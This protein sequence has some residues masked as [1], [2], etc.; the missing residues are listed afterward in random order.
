MPLY[1]KI[2]C[3]LRS[4][5]ETRKVKVGD[6]L[7]AEPELQRI[8]GTSRAP[9]RQAMSLLENER[10]VI[11][12]PGKGTFVS[13]ANIPTSWWLNFSPFRQHFE[14]E[15]HDTQTRVL[16]LEERVP[17]GFVNDFFVLGT[18]CSVTY[19]ERIRSVRHQPVIMNR[20]YVHP[21]Y[22]FSGFLEVEKHFSLRI[23]LMEK[24]SVEITRVDDVLTSILAPDED[25]EKN[26]GISNTTPLLALKRY[27]YAEDIPVMIDMSYVKTEIW[28]YRASFQ[29]T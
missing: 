10:L 26:L 12:R 20:L 1:H 5:I 19:I 23:F 9:V 29:K 28:D 4:Q 17:P 24:F 16:L 8:F 25:I 14:E 22:K 3:A 7:P 2:Y 21:Q 27:M 6:L 11:R 13:S 18:T 15:W